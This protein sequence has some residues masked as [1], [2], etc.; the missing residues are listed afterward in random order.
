ML[1]NTW[2]LPAFCLASLLADPL[3]T[4]AP[5]N[6]LFGDDGGCCHITLCTSPPVMLLEE[7]LILGAVLGD[8]DR[9]VSAVEEYTV[10]M[11]SLPPTTTLDEQDRG[12]TT[13]GHSSW[14]SPGKFDRPVIHRL[15]EAGGETSH[16]WEDREKI[17]EVD[18]FRGHPVMGLKL[19]SVGGPIIGKLVGNS[20]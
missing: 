19:Y 9:V 16:G 7:V 8:E 15:V 14:L 1:A 20:S 4:P 17:S 2:P 12:P 5:A 6:V 3:P 10:T 18:A 11:G 13:S